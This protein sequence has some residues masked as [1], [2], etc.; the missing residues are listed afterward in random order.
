MRTTAVSKTTSRLHALL[1]YYE[2]LFLYTLERSRGI[3]CNL[4]F[5]RLGSRLCEGSG[6]RLGLV[7]RVILQ[8][9]VGYA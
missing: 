7:L 5:L 2:L 6:V 9:D 8:L 1:E 4:G 3:L